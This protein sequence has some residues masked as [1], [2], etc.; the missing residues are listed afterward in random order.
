MSDETFWWNTTAGLSEKIRGIDV[1]PSWEAFKDEYDTPTAS[2][3]RLSAW[4]ESRPG[5]CISTHL[6][7]LRE[8]ATI[9][10]G[11][12]ERGCQSP[13]LRNLTES[14]AAKKLA[15]I[16]LDLVSKRGVGLLAELASDARA[17]HCTTG[18][19]RNLADAVWS[20]I[21]FCERTRKLPTKKELNIEA[22]RIDHL[23]RLSDKGCFELTKGPRFGK[24][25]KKRYK[26]YAF[27]RVD[28]NA[29][30]Y[31]C[32]KHEWENERWEKS[33]YSGILKK[34]GLQGLPKG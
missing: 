34:A 23:I 22:N 9:V 28:G 16:V 18:Q 4:S 14:K 12:K 10:L 13:K 1:C 29:T 17:V 27:E 15:N 30:L 7:D 5:W 25:V 19:P 21:R 6:I 2:N 11:H 3:N 32:P 24:L 33:D 31:V 26:I 8:L 20:L